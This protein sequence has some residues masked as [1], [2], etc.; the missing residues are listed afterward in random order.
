[1]PTLRVGGRTI[2]GDSRKVGPYF[3]A[4]RRELYDRYLMQ[5]VR[6]GHA[7][8]AFET[9]EELD[10]LRKAAA[11]GKQTFK[12]DRAALR[13]HPTPESRLLAMAEADAQGKPYVI[14]FLVPDEPVHVMDQVL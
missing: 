11:A 5:L 7:Y 1:G 6:D 14:R 4:Q 3:Q 13:Q 2:G 9:P 12:Y 10:A 8:P